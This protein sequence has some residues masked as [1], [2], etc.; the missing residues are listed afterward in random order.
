MTDDNNTTGEHPTAWWA[1]ESEAPDI[2]CE[3]CSDAKRDRYYYER[4]PTWML[5]CECTVCLN[6][7]T[8]I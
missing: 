8:S 5:P 2:L 4:I 7:I 3:D 6:K 1:P